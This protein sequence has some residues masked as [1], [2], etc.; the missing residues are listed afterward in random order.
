[1]PNQ[2]RKKEP[3]KFLNVTVTAI[4]ERRCLVSFITAVVGDAMLDRY[5]YGE[6]SR[7]SPEAPVP[8]VKITNEVLSPGGAAHVAASVQSLNQPSVLF[9][10]V[11]PDEEGKKLLFG[12]DI[13][14]VSCSSVELTDWS[15]TVKTRVIANGNTQVLRYDRELPIQKSPTYPEFISKVIF[16]LKSMALD[17]NA[18]II[19][20]YN[21]NTISD[22]LV[23]AIQELVLDNKHITLFVDAKPD[24]LGKW[25]A[26][27]C[28]TPNFSESLKFLNKP[29]Q[30]SSDLSKDDKFCENVALE[31]AEKLE[32]LFL[33]VVTRAQHGC[34]W[35][36]RPTNSCGSLPAFGTCKSDVIGA[37]DT[38]ISALT[39]AFNEN[40]S[41]EE[42]IKF[43]NAASALAVGKPGTTVVHRMELDSYLTSSKTGSSK[44][45][46]MSQAAAVDWARQ[47]R[48]TNEKIVFANGCFDL[49]HAGHVHLLEQAKL[50]GDYLLVGVNDDQSV[51]ALKG[52]GRPVVSAVN[53]VRM[54]SAL[55]C[56]DAVV[57]FSQH[58]L[59]P[60]VEAIKPDVLV[61]G[62]EYKDSA[63]PGS[64]SVAKFGGQ[65]LLV[66]MQKG[67]GTTKTVE[68]IRRKA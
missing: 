18:I 11:G 25:S 34:S 36:H 14:N 4:L 30:P 24:T 9:T 29:F 53:R 59:E 39:V 17:L 63:I 19:S 27:D 7:I 51:K 52:D 20:D 1:V 26:A 58:E 47:L 61:K 10:A 42:A 41:H 21:K 57:V 37:G 45:K 40:K 65:V 60:L 35:Y 6:V 55:E 23:E 44:S 64:I 31:I 48:S 22:E 67:L 16:K 38:F 66:D 13:L 15:T 33:V 49:L 43:A 54:L 2:I 56:V 28:I 12:L 50:A 68:E 32:N 5:I 46:I 8:V 62:N 3:Q